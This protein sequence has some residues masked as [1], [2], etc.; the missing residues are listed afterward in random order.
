MLYAAKQMA[1]RRQSDVWSFDLPRGDVDGGMELYSSERYYR[2]YS[3]I[4]SGSVIVHYE[5]R[6]A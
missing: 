2:H 3:R 5:E 4:R 1:S 6:R